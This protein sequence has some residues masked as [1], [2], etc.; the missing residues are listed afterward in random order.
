MLC[1]EQEQVGQIKER[2]EHKMLLKH[3]PSEF[4][5]FLDHVLGL[6]YF[7]KPDYQVLEPQLFH[8]K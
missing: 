2:Y 7:T 4:Y 1:A 8:L 6:D 3:M 5:I